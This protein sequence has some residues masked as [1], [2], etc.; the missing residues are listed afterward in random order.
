M[1]AELGGRQGEDQPPV[2]VV[3]VAKAEDVAKERPR[4]LRV[5]RV[6]QRMNAVDHSRNYPRRRLCGVP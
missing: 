5:L 3:D 1:D 6:D 4:R 2:A